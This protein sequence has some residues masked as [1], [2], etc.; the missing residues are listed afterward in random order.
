M[1]AVA[2]NLF[3]IKT[4][5]KISP[6]GLERFPRANFEVAGEI[7]AP[8]AI[9][10]RSHKVD[11]DGDVPIGVQAIARCGAG[12][13]NIPVDVMTERG[14]VVFNTPGSNANAV[15]ELVLCGLFLSS[16]GIAQGI[17]WSNEL[18]IPD[19]GEMDKAVEKGKKNFGGVELAGKTLGVV[20]LGNIGAQVVHSALALGMNVIGYDPALSLEAAWRLPGRAVKR[21]D[22]LEPLLAQ[23]DYVSLHVP[24][25]EAT[26]NMLNDETLS[27]MQSHTHIL[28]FSRGGL[29]DN[30]A[31]KKLWAN[32][33]TGKYISDFPSLDMIGE[34]NYI[35]MPHLGASTDEAEEESAKMAADEIIE[36]LH[37]GSIINS[38]NYPAV[39]LP[40]VK[41][42]QSRVCICN[43]NVPNVISSVT[44]I[45]STAGHNVDDLVNKSRGDFSYNAIDINGGQPSVDTMK[46]LAALEG[47]L[48]C[49]L[50]SSEGEVWQSLSSE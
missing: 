1:S 12:V 14:V 6:V 47:V 20:G 33:H 23:C 22:A 5:N 11:A 38:V 16:R 13:N 15:K 36:F 4:F 46:E 48:S 35:P 44:S 39:T 21:V 2:K 49:R 30:E 24:M 10:L 28:N 3:K 40:S 50:L 17:Q 27:A 31:V 18:N 37:T 45:L 34:P 29:V 25:M 19:V 8:D 41:D 26:K 42:A 43:Q 32:G 9:M 7:S